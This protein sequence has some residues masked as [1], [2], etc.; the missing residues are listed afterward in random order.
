[1]A[2]YSEPNIQGIVKPRFPGSFAGVTE[3]QDQHEPN[4]IGIDQS[5]FPGTKNPLKI[6]E[7]NFDGPDQST[8]IIDTSPFSRTAILAGSPKLSTTDPIQGRSSLVLDGAN[9]FITYAAS[10]D[11]SLGN[12]DFYWTFRLRTTQNKNMLILGM[13]NCFFGMN[14]GF[15]ALYSN[16]INFN[17]S[18]IS[19][20][21]INDGLPHLFEFRKHNNLIE[22]SIDRQVFCRAANA[23]FEPDGRPFHIGGYQAES[24]NFEGTIDTFLFLK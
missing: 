2:Q 18:K 11:F 3:I 16:I 14:D 9:D 7:L 5:H 22:A 8:S 23:S 17:A 13:G 6:L 21:R 24:R 12:E 10:T 19:N 15:V 20:P 4:I 1:M